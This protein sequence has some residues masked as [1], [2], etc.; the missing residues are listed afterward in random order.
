M[1]VYKT[2]FVS[3]RIFV[4]FRCLDFSFF[5]SFRYLN[6]ELSTVLSMTTNTPSYVS[7]VEKRWS[8]GFGDSR[9]SFTLIRRLPRRRQYR[10]KDYQVWI[11]L[12]EWVGVRR[13]SVVSGQEPFDYYSHVF[14]YFWSICP[15]ENSLLSFL[16]VPMSWSQN[17]VG[18][19][20][21][22]MGLI[23]FLSVPDSQFFRLHVFIHYS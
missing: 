4:T 17:R 21:R 12:K 20:V 19:T 6:L 15:T 1:S 3:Q 10:S 11:D 18:H 16:P 23:L 8:R 13:G 22:R 7:W 5:F 9:S 14:V 2:S